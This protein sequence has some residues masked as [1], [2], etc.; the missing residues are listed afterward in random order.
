MGIPEI[1][2]GAVLIL[3]SLVIVLVVLAQDSKDDG[4]TSAIGGGYNSSFYENNM[5]RTKDAKLSRF[6]RFSAVLIFVITLALNVL[7]NFN[8]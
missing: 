6:T 4:L 1:V 5:A 2:A 7:A 3:C 8:K